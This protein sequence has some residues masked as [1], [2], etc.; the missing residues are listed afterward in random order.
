VVKR[1]IS[2]LPVRGSVAAVASATWI[3]R[4]ASETSSGVTTVLKLSQH[5]LEKHDVSDNQRVFT[6]VLHTPRTD[7][8][9]LPAG[10]L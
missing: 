10:E 7:E 3:K 9:F 4:V 8:S 6:E 5:D 1:S 2:I